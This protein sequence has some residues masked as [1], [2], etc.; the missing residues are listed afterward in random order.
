MESN[1]ALDIMHSNSNQQRSEKEIFIVCP[2]L[3]VL[4]TLV[5]V[6]RTTESSI[7][8]IERVTVKIKAT[9]IRTFVLSC[10]NMK[11]KCSVPL[12]WIRE[13]TTLFVVCFPMIGLTWES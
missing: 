5:I 6:I 7:M 2:T 1:S 13:E 4:I 3:I 9:F 10:I 8:R 12:E 11:S